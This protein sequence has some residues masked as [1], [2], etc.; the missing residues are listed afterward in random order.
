MVICWKSMTFRGSRFEGLEAG[1][2]LVVLEDKG[3]RSGWVVGWVVGE[4][5]NMIR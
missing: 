3:G 2:R 5:V 4:E 1:V